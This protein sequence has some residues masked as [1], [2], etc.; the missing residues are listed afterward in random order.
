MNRKILSEIA[1]NYPKACANLVETAKT[2]L[3]K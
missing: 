2:Q 3:I 1:I